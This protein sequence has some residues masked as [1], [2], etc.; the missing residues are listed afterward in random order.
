MKKENENNNKSNNYRYSSYRRIKKEND[1]IS[2]QNMNNINNNIKS[3][4]SSLK[5]DINTNIIANDL[6]SV[7]ENTNKNNNTKENLSKDKINALK[8]DH[9]SIYDLI[10]TKC[11]LNIDL[12][13][14]Y[15]HNYEPSKTSK[16]KMGIIKSYGVNTFQ[17]IVRDYNEDRVSI[18]VNMNKPRGYY[19]RIWPRVS[20][21]GIY[22]GHGGEA[23]SE[24][25]RD[26]LHDFI[27]HNNE[28]FPENIPEAI[29]LAFNKAEK[30]FI[31]NYALDKKK[32]L[33]DKSG[34]CAVILLIVDN[35]IYVANVG[36]S[37]CLLSMGNGNKYIEVTKDHKPNSPEELER[38]KKYGG[39]IYQTQNYIK[40]AKNV[41]LIGKKILGPYRVSPGNLSVSRTIGDIEAKSEKYGGN[42]NVVIAK[43]DIFVYDLNKDDIDFFILGCD[44]IFD[45]LTSDEVINCAWM[46][47]NNKDSIVVNQCKDVHQQSGIITDLIMKSAL[48]RKSFDNVTCLFISF[49]ELGIGNN[50]LSENNNNNI[51][52]NDSQIKLSSLDF[53]TNNIRNNNTRNVRRSYTSSMTNR[54]NSV[55]EIK[56]K[57][58]YNNNYNQKINSNETNK[59]QYNSRNRNDTNN[60]IELKNYQI[61]H[62]NNINEKSSNNTYKIW[63]YNNTNN[64]KKDSN[65]NNNKISIR[66]SYIMNKR[67][68]KINEINNTENAETVNKRQYKYVIQTNNT[69]NEKNL[70]KPYDNNLNTN[71]KSTNTT[72]RRNYS[73]YISNNNNY[74]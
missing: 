2:T 4:D 72:T 33:K 27:V 46:V 36:D 18:I 32:E 1:N 22:D 63:N 71:L 56:N 26:N 74:K 60:K 13:R 14:Y 50:I 40:K 16:K 10:G 9:L 28:F 29:K 58:N 20:F 19:K 54:I 8:S 39:K 53:N 25:L 51:N 37:R 49:K 17:G 15:F 70:N 38:I 52:D 64:N 44:G 67:S 68:S 6:F 47:Y 66:K 30:N 57:E 3:N 45:Q 61:N 59:I 48:A 31:D 62:I 7:K 11:N 65:T 12:L 42:P 43:P 69:I 73:F 35:K 21:F 55:N 23:C 34:S 41:K 24:F 5:S